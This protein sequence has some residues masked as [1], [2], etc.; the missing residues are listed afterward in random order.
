MQT[1]NSLM[2]SS[3]FNFWHRMQAFRSPRH[4]SLGQQQRGRFGE[5][6]GDLEIV[7]SRAKINQ[8]KYDCAEYKEIIQAEPLTDE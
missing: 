3:R 2:Y 8:R 1:I 5:I 6:Q 7:I 4:E